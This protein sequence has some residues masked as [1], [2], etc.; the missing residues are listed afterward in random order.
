MGYFY[1]MESDKN[2]L[3]SKQENNEELVNTAKLNKKKTYKSKP[4][5]INDNSESNISSNKQKFLENKEALKKEEEKM[6][7]DSEG[8]ESEDY[9]SESG[10]E[11][12]ENMNDDDFYDKSEDF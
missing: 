9:L 6:N 1:L 10:E 4:V 3:S 8:D 12:Y 11:D 2:F 7:I 5:S